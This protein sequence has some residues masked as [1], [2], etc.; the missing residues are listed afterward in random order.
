MFSLDILV[1]VGAFLFLLAYLVRDQILLRGLIILGTIFYIIYYFFMETPL[2]SA[3]L[4]NSSFVVINLIMIVV[5]YSDRASFVMTEREKKLY[6]V[7]TTLSPGEFK[8]LL[9]IA[10]WFDGSSEEQITTE[11]EIPEC[12]YFIIDGEALITRDDKKFLVGPNVFIGELAYL[13]KKPA[14]ATVKL[15]EKVVGISWKTS[16]LTKLL[17]SNP[18]MK[19]AFDG[20][21]NQDLAAKLAK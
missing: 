14:T 17:A 11:G 8:K 1:H 2:W 20:L 7:F 9:K 18:Q 19:I 5:I 16:S 4:W 12:L 21:L 10:D 15:T 13:I 3:L 6:Q